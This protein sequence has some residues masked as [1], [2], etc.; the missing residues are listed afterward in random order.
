MIALV[1]GVGVAISVCNR[2]VNSLVGVAISASLLPPAVN[3]GI[4]FAF[5]GIVQIKSLLVRG[6]RALF[7]Y[8]L[9]RIK[10]VRACAH[11]I[12]ACLRAFNT[13]LLA[14][15]QYLRAFSSRVFSRTLTRTIPLLLL[16]RLIRLVGHTLS[17]AEH[18]GEG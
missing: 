9:V 3:C 7:Q 2:N 18:G 4:C 11:S 13:C 6:M 10:Y 16:R 8:V 5:A 15:I 17:I 14:R 1:S 12:R